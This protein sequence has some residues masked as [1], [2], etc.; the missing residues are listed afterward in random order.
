MGRSTGR[1]IQLYPPIK[2]IWIELHWSDMGQ[3]TKKFANVQEL[4]QFLKDN[5]L[6]AQAVGYIARAPKLNEMKMPD[7]YMS[8]PAGEQKIWIER[9]KEVL[10]QSGKVSFR[11]RVFDNENL[12]ESVLRELQ[13]RR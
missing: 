2:E 3:T 13:N 7:S 6:L 10:S 8:L 4:A 9:A 5:P 1:E 11:G 12:L